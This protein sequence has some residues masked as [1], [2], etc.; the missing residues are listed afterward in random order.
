MKNNIKYYKQTDGSTITGFC[1]FT[2]TASDHPKFPG[3]KSYDA[4][5]V[6]VVQDEQ[7]CTV[8]PGIASDESLK[9]VDGKGNKFGKFPIEVSKEEWLHLTALVTKFINEAEEYAIQR[10]PVQVD[11]K[12]ETT[13]KNHIDE[14]VTSQ[15][16]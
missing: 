15:I 2:D 6:Q 4:I 16:N 1:I 3:E 5:F 11:F 13:E 14:T 12:V 8:T 9:N 7:F 10:S